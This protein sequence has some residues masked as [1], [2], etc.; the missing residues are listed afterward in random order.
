MKGTRGAL[1][2]CQI[3][4]NTA[5]ATNGRASTGPGLSGN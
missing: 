4:W 3:S 5:T 2:D 1:Y